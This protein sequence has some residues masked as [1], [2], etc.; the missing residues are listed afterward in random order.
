ME[1]TIKGL[2]IKLGLSTE[3]S[4]EPYYPQTRDRDDVSVLKCKKSGVI[5]LN[6]TD[7]I[8]EDYY[9]N[10]DQWVEFDN[11]SYLELLAECED[12]DFRRLD[13]IEPFIE[14]KVWV[15]YGAG[16]GG[17]LL[18]GEE[19]TKRAYAVERQKKAVEQLKKDKNIIVCENF[20]DI[21]EQ[22][23][24]VTLFHVL[25]HFKDPIQKLKEIYDKLLDG[26]TLV[27]EVP[28]ARDFLLSILNVESFKKTFMWSEHLILHTQKSLKKTL[29]EAGFEKVEI[30][31]IQRY[32]LSNHLYWLKNGLPN[33]HKHFSFLNSKGMD[34]Q[35]E[36]TLKSIDACDTLIAFAYKK[37]KI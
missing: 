12:D 4:F 20:S 5:I 11:K 30:Q 19:I 35:Y 21:S 6:R 13:T 17:L 28:H 18:N 7:H 3:D 23:D 33:G 27:V 2:L 37:P 25:E 29:T 32:P 24:V 16:A 26:G 22:V 8:T 1:N 15:D 9:N 10:I 31:P 34:K 14:N 36:K